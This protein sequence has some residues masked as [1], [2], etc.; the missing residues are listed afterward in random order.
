MPF[1]THDIR[2]SVAPV[3]KRKKLDLERFI[4]FFLIAISNKLTTNASRHMMKQFNCGVTEWRILSMLAVEPNIPPGRITTVVGIDKS[5]VS[6]S[7]RL[8]EKRGCIT[9]LSDP[10]HG[11]RLL[12]SLTP[13]GQAM[14]DEIIDAVL[15]REQTMLTGLS[16][17]DRERLT[18]YLKRILANIPLVVAQTRAQMGEEGA[19]DEDE[20][21]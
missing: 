13:A 4:P 9:V 17:D 11:R 20:G 15:D 8:L 12:L 21:D 19:A 5:S 2:I 18:D 16:P 10:S 6:R 7:L 3:P 14:H 1:K